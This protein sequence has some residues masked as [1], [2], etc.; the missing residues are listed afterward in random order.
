MEDM[1]FLRIMARR[2]AGFFIVVILTGFALAFAL[3]TVIG[4]PNMLKQSLRSSGIY[5][6]VVDDVLAASATTGQSHAAG[7]VPFNDPGVRQAAQKSFPPSLL[8]A[9][10]EQVI[11]GVYHWLDGRVP[12]PDFKVDL[13][14]A[15]IGLANNVADYARARVSTLPVCTAVQLQTLGSTSVDAFAIPCNPPGLDL[16]AV[17]TQVYGDIANNKEFLAEPVITAGSLPKDAG[18]RTVFQNAAGAPSV[19]RRVKLYTRLYIPVILLV[20]AVYILLHESRR[21]GLRRAGKLLVITG[22][23]LAVLGLVADIIVGG[24]T[25]SQRIQ[26][27]A[28]D[29]GLQL[30]VRHVARYMGHAYIYAV[31]ALAVGYIVLGLSALGMVW[32][33]NR[34]KIRRGTL[35]DKKGQH[36]PAGEPNSSSIHKAAAKKAL[37]KNRDATKDRSEK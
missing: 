10:S 13:A 34:R 15:K 7:S 27:A 9:G 16:D 1:S 29:A 17:R 5:S 28:V 6:A 37:R 19:F 21:Q 14:G 12:Q 35:R 2:S 18:G 33:I 24:V 11:D 32:G 4:T 30:P 25:S 22:L 26:L 31:L 3:V 8:Q 23:G 20:F 36:L